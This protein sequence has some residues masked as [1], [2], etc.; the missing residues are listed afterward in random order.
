MRN[1]IAVL[2]ISFLT[3]GMMF[4]VGAR[5]DGPANT[6]EN[7]F[8]FTAIADGQR[9]LTLAN[10][11]SGYAATTAMNAL[12]VTDPYANGA[13]F[14]TATQS[15]VTL[16]GS[17]G[18]QT[19][20]AANAARKYAIV[21]LTTSTSPVYVK[22]GAGYLSVTNT[23][24]TGGIPLY[25]Q[26]SSYELNNTNLYSGIVTANVASGQSAVLYVTEGQ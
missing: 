11:T 18:S 2:A 26:G 17:V 16:T 8:T 19:V 21:A 15:I 9:S 22:L 24:S 6:G 20:L 10:V 3:A 13:R 14:T 25:S 7:I 5:A 4:A 12:V 23:V 1:W